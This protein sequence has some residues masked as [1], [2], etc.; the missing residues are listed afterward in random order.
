MTILSLCISYLLPS[1][2]DLALSNICNQIL[3]FQGNI[4]AENHAK[5]QFVYS[6]QSEEFSLY[7]EVES[8]ILSFDFKLPVVVCYSGTKGVA[9]SRNKALKAASSMYIWFLD[10]DCLLE[11]SA[12]DFIDFICDYKLP[13]LFLQS[14]KANRKDIKK[15]IQFAFNKPTKVSFFR[16]LY[17]LKTIASAA[18]YNIVVS[19]NYLS[20]SPWVRFDPLLGLG[21]YY[22]QSDEA[23]FL[24]HLFK[25]MAKSKVIYF[26]YYPTPFLLAESKSHLVLGSNLIASLQSK[27]Y[28]LARSSSFFP[29]TLLALPFLALTFSIKFYSALPFLTTFSAVVQG[30]LNALADQK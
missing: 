21:T 15:I 12:D 22:H 20:S 8:S 7:Q 23:L 27:G 9:L 18:T 28:V 29:L 4:R 1:D 10:I 11:S 3:N 25:A 2:I 17:T 14:D 24:I 19:K 13:F 26:Y 16:I 5:I 30:Y 6:L